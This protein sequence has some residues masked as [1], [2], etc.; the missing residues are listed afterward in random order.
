MVASTD[1]LVNRLRWLSK[2][3]EDAD[4]LTEGLETS[5]KSIDVYRE[6]GAMTLQVWNCLKWCD[7]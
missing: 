6:L 4:D 7:I 5:Q 3:T 1:L 2:T